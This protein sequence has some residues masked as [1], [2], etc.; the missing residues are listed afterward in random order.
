[1]PGMR[2]RPEGE[3]N[4]REGYPSCRRS[5]IT[6]RGRNGPQL[7]GQSVPHAD[8][9][10]LSVGH[11][12]VTKA[13][14]GYRNCLADHS[15]EQEKHLREGIVGSCALSSCVG[16]PVPPESTSSPS[17]AHVDNNG[18]QSYA[19]AA[20]SPATRSTG[21]SLSSGGETRCFQATCCR[22]WPSHASVQSLRC[23]SR[24][25]PV[26]C[27]LRRH[28]HVGGSDSTSAVCAACDNA[29]LY[30]QVEL[31]LIALR[32]AHGY[33]THQVLWPGCPTPA[34]TPPDLSA[35][36]F[37]LPP[38]P[39]KKRKAACRQEW[40]ARNG[41]PMICRRKLRRLE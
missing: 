35:S 33:A 16:P 17:G 38:A 29:E 34:S 40:R 13:Q 11:D 9:S 37:D 20:A 27:H 24:T 1:M 19:A 3:G 8:A 4:H 10:T 2:H 23:R 5:S 15:T 30:G 12:Q 18:V 36:S 31:L 6:H 26:D 28:P 25:C 32:V 14:A 41:R 39:S 22:P 7:R 21:R